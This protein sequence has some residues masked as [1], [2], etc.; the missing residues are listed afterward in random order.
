MNLGTRIIGF[1]GNGVG[2]V[3]SRRMG[4]LIVEHETQYGRSVDSP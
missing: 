4:S 2:L 1:E 3:T